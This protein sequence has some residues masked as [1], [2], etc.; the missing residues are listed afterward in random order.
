MKT[1]VLI[2]LALAS[3]ASC[4]SNSSETTVSSTSL[5]SFS[6]QARDSQAKAIDDIGSLQNAIN[7]LF[8]TA[9]GEPVEVLPGESIADVS[10][11]ASSL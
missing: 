9:D 4:H 8:G 3:L 11:R 6:T 10:H 1:F 2:G 7:A 5:N